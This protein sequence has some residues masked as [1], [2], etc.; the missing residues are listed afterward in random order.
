METNARIAELIDRRQPFV[1]ATVVRAEPPTSAHTGD[2]AIVLPDGTIE[3]FVGGQCAE[4]SVRRAAL[5]ALQS[6]ES[7]LLRVLPDG[8]AQFPE[9]PGATVVVNQCLS[10]GALEIFLAPRLPAARLYLMGTNP[11][12]DAVAELARM[13]AFQIERVE[14]G[15]RPDG[16][17]AAV[18]VG[19]GGNE[20]ESIRAALD[21]GVGYIGLVASR[22][23]GASVLDQLELD[24]AERARI[25]TPAGL[26]IGARTPAEI[27]LSILAQIVQGIRLGELARRSPALDAALA[28]AAQD[29]VTDPNCGM[30]VTVRAETPRVEL[31][32]QTYWFCSTGCRDRF[33]SERSP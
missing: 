9:A 8:Q 20:A 23:R 3:G 2:E 12:A 18:I 21:A 26:P 16:A 14:E 25:H 7:V 22:I 4:S 13:L 30:T 27:A 28:A 19:L 29:T 32:G 17:V 31:D 24:E 33:L 6:E 1:H 15:G 10:G 11:A 5:D